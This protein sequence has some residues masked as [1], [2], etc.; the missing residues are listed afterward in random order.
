[1]KSQG[2]K[3][4][5]IPISVPKLDGNELNYVSSTGIGSLASI[6]KELEPKN[7]DLIFININQKES[8]VFSLLGVEQIFTV[9]E[10][11]EEAVKHFNYL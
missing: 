11:K 2:W 1:M 4:I 6:I 10:N 3:S 5:R 9:K 8:E 7:G